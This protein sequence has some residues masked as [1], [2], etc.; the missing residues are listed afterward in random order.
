M[1][2]PCCDKVKFINSM[3]TSLCHFLSL[4][5]CHQ[6]PCSEQKLDTLTLISK[7]AL[8]VTSYYDIDTNMMNVMSCSPTKT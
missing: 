5:L 1:F 3:W 6:S 2:H 8:L 4:S 7:T